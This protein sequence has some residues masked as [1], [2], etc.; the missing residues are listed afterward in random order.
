MIDLSGRR[1][2]RRAVASD[3]G[4]MLV[5]ERIPLWPHLRGRRDEERPAESRYQRGALFGQKR[6]DD[7]IGA[8]L[9]MTERSERCVDAHW[10]AGELELA[11]PAAKVRE[12]DVAHR[13]DG[14]PLGTSPDQRPRCQMSGNQ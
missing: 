10:M 3:V 11:N 4:R 9:H 8:T 14:T 12:G 2:I 6:F 5:V 13:L 7:G 1:R